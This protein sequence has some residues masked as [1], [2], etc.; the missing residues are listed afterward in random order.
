MDFSESEERSESERG[1]GSA[2]DITD[3]IA[4]SLLSSHTLAESYVGLDCE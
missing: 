1:S 3:L 2:F 4:S